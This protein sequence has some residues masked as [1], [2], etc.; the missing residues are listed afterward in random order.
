VQQ[1]ALVD[2]EVEV[3]ERVVPA[4]VA[5][6]LREPGEREVVR[7]ADAQ[8]PA[9]PVA[10]EV[11]RRLLGRGE[12]VAREAD[13]RLAV[14]R[15]RYRVRVPQHQHPPDLPLQAA[16]VLADG[17]LLQAEPG[18]RAGEAAG[19]LDGEEGREELRI[20]AGHKRS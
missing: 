12:D 3:D 8:P 6:D 19:L 2:R 16:D 4:E 18:R 11:G 20:I 17:R 9:R 15:Q 1:A 7:D 13:H 14:R 10:A 5:Q